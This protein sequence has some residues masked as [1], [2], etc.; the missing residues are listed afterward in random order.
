MSLLCR[1][2]VSWCNGIK[3]YLLHI[4]VYVFNVLRTFLPGQGGTGTVMG[5]WEVTVVMEEKVVMGDLKGAID[6]HFNFIVA[7]L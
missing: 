6:G 2:G 4:I 3:E 5:G 1:F 7:S